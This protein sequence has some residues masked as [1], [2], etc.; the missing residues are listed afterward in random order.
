MIITSIIFAKILLENEKIKL[1]TKNIILIII[2]II[3]YSIVIGNLYGVLKTLILCIIYIILYRNLYSISY[4]KSLFLAFEHIIVIII[5]DLFILFSCVYI[6]GFDTEV[7]NIIYSKTIYYTFIVDLLFIIFTYILRKPLRKISNV[8]IDNNKAIIMYFII[9]LFSIL[10]VFY[11][12]Y[13]NVNTSTTKE[14]ILGIIV[15]ISFV[16]ILFSLIKQKLENMKLVVKYDKLLEF[17]KTYEKELD[18]QKTLRHESKN[19]L[20]TVRDKIIHKDKE[21][22]VMEYLN[23]I[24]AEHVKGENE[25]YTSFQYLPANGI[26]GLFYYKAREAEDY[27]I[28]TSINVSPKVENSHL[29]KLD[30]NDSKDLCRIIGVYLDNAIEASKESDKKML[31]IE[32]YKRNSD[33]EMIISNTYN[34]VIDTD[35][36]GKRKYTTKGKN[37]GYGL[38]LVNKIIEKNKRYETKKVI[39][40]EL[41]EQRIIIK[42]P[43][44]K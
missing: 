25:K 6:L 20:I 35:N 30:T 21:V 41:Y 29:F 24:I 5:P 23:N 17:I 44:N 34:G 8:E 36:I 22:P 16:L 27:G 28:K 15:I 43:I 33:I 12:E 38:M 40:E 9:S 19:Q 14:L 39:T 31:G 37:H 3:L 13:S 1:N 7:F 4:S 11:T 18:E 42:K 32:I 2:A 26:K 10:V